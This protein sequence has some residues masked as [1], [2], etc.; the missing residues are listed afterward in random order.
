MKRQVEQVSRRRIAL[1][2]QPLLPS[3]REETAAVAPGIERPVDE[4]PS[5]EAVLEPSNLRRA[6]RQVIGNGGSPGVDGMGVKELPG[7][8]REHWPSLKADLLSGFYRPQP[9]RR[10]E[11]PK[12]S[13]GV[14]K[15]GIPTVVDRF[16][17]QA[18]MQV[19][20]QHWDP[21]FSEH[22]YGFRPGRSAHQAV[23]RAQG[24][25]RDRRRWVVDLDLEKFFDRVNHDK[26]M[27]EVAKRV[28]DQRLLALIRRYLRA[29]VMEH[30]VVSP[31]TMGTPQGGPLSPLLSNL[32][33]DR[34]DRELERRRHH[35]VR[36]ADDCNIYVV[37]RR[38]GER[39]LS[40]ITRFLETKLKLQVN[41][42]KSAVDRPW[43]RSFLG[44]SFTRATPRRTVGVKALHAFKDRVREL[45]HRNR[46]ASLGTVIR[47]LTP[48]LCGWRA[49]YGF[50]ETRVPL[51]LL[52]CWVRRK[53]RCYVWKQW[54][55]ARRRE[56]QR[57]GIPPEEAGVG[58]C[59]LG[60]WR[61][62]LHP[63]TNRALSDAFFAARGLP[64]LCAVP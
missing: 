55:P 15:L 11:I 8:L 3:L 56:L 37:T 16:L 23:A 34:L 51:H 29:G 10:V 18:L 33:L 19:L 45:T 31:S 4:G 61:M 54:G 12:A 20:Q 58:G 35:F 42:A 41:R 28:T 52:D 25:L 53:L 13:G 40:S 50:S 39:V 57:L 47:D 32:L 30:G 49:Y 21:T 59:S 14:R 1:D 44:F 22:S 2:Q 27:G 62:S 7:Y 17:Q 36:Y 48:F 43:N 6:V 5:L 38:A 26:L 63:V 60:P 9:V 46:G 24:Y 64:S